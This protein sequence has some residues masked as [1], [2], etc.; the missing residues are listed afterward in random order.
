MP[1]LRRL[2]SGDGTGP[3]LRPEFGFYPKWDKGKQPLALIIER[4]RQV[5]LLVQKSGFESQRT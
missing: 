2:G 1:I 4:S 5:L 3:F